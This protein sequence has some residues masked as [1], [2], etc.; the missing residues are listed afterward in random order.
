MILDE[1]LVFFAALLA[2]V[3]AVALAP[4][5]LLINGLIALT[6]FMIGIFVDGFTISRIGKKREERSF[7]QRSLGWVWLLAIFGGLFLIFAWP[8]ISQREITIVVTDGYVAP[9]ASLIVEK[10]DGQEHL[11]TDTE[12]KVII[13]R[14]GVTSLSIKSSR[15]VEKSWSKDEI[16]DELLVERT[17]LGAGL[18]FLKDRLLKPVKSSN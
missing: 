14:F 15:Y 1:L 13:P 11:R 2:P 9:L 12:G 16:E 4:I 3:A 5:I 7:A 6:E 10:G 8:K 18:D 17:V